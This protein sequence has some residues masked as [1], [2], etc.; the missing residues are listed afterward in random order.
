MGFLSSLRRFPRLFGIALGCVIATFALL[1]TQAVFL[2]Y[3]RWTAPE[4]ETTWD[5]PGLA[6]NRENRVRYRANGELIYD[7]TYR[8]DGAGNRVTPQPEK[9]TNSR[10]LF[11]GCSFTFGDGVE[12]DETLPA[13]VARTLPESG[14]VNLGHGGYGAANILYMLQRR[15]TF[16]PYRGG[17]AAMVYVYIPAHVRRSIGSMRI[18]ANYGANFPHYV[19]E[20]G[21]VVRDRTF[22]YARPWRQKAYSYLV[23]EPILKHFNIDLPPAFTDEHFRFTARLIAEC[24]NVFRESFP[25]QEFVVVIYPTETD[26][27]SMRRIVPYL[28]ELGVPCL[29]Y[30]DAFEGRD[31]RVFLPF[32]RHPTAE[33]HRIIGER[34]AGDLSRIL[35]K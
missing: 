24:R 11:V 10:I 28:E 18:V 26:L 1:L 32:D 19:I 5:P 33:G 20:D 21:N 13:V 30:A 22:A 34:L 29:D 27:F 35:S 14:V 7:V 23:H 2:L 9:G 16:E 8:L 4:I 31:E 15:E 3:D 6:P 17:D 12:D 25:E